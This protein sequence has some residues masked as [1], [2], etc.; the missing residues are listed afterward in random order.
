MPETYE[1]TSVREITDVS[2]ESGDLLDYIEADAKTKP[3]GVHFSV[4]VPYAEGG[5]GAITGLLAAKAAEL[6]SVFGTD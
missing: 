4:R 6:E 3:H 1:V 5:A 2:P